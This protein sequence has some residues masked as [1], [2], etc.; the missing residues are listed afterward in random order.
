LSWYALRSKPNKEFLLHEQLLARNIEC[1]FPR[2]KVN[3]VN[4]RSR[5]VQ[6]YFPGYI[7][8]KVDLEN[9]GSNTFK[10]MPYAQRLVSFDGIPAAVPSPI[11]NQLRT[12]LRTINDRGGLETGGFTPGEA[13]I[14]T[15]GPFEG[16]EGIFDTQLSGS[17]RV[18]VLL[19][20]LNGRQLPV[21]IK[22]DQVTRNKTKP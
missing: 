3:P 6:P 13:I 8:V 1:F 19:N 5:K 21:E 7:F 18:K 14:L 10:W 17:D 11:I 20:L 4:L 15:D 22:A 12:T 2:V 9:L 16:Y